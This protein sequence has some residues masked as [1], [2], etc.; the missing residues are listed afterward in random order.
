MK[1]TI[2]FEISETSPIIFAL[3]TVMSSFLQAFIVHGTNN[4][5]SGMKKGVAFLT[6]INTAHNS[7]SRTLFRNA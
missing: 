5:G 2:L 4:F 3:K 1:V 6:N 7:K